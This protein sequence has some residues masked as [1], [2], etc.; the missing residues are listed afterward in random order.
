MPKHFEPKQ[1]QSAIN[2]NTSTAQEAAI[3]SNA[4][5]LKLW[6]CVLFTELSDTTPRFQGKT[7]SFDFLSTSQTHPTDC[8]SY[9]IGGK[10]NS[11]NIS[12]VGPHDHLL[13]IAPLF[14]LVWFIDASFGLFGCPCYILTQGWIYFPNFLFL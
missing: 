7:I 13:D 4:E 6:N 2:L 5:L 14:A 10:F 12:R 3:Y 1:V 8:Y 11:N 9:S